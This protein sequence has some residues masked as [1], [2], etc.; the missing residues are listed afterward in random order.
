MEQYFTG[1]I[2]LV[3]LTTLTT[4]SRLHTIDNLTFNLSILGFKEGS[5][6]IFWL[7]WTFQFVRTVILKLLCLRVWHV[8]VCLLVT[9]LSLLDITCLTCHDSLET[10]SGHWW[11][12]TRC[13]TVCSAATH[14]E[15]TA[16]CTTLY[17]SGL[18]I[19]S[20]N[21]LIAMNDELLSH[22]TLSANWYFV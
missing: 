6:T 1:V 15:G 2:H 9:W 13:Y 20:Q 4:Q 19:F 5:Q 12:W 3:A 22:E 21:T 11:W 18:K 16:S 7:T 8:D 10:E 17:T 14:R